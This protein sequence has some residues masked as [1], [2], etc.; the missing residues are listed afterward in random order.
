MSNDLIVERLKAF[1]TLLNYA[2]AE[3]RLILMDGARLPFTEALDDPIAVFKFP[4]PCLET[5]G[6]RQIKLFTPAPTLV[7]RS[8]VVKWG[9]FINAADE[10]IADVEVA[11]LGSAGEVIIDSNTTTLYVGGEVS[12]TGVVLRERV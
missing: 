5:T 6:D 7:L 1:C 9:R 2:G 8:G 4:S 11:P 3:G 12:L 10:A